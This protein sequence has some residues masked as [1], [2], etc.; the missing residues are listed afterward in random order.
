ML[1]IDLDHFKS[2]NDRFGHAVGD[3]ALQELFADI[4]KAHIGLAGT[5]GRWGGDEFV[6]VLYNASREIA[7]TARTHPGRWKRRQGNI[8]GRLVNATVISTGKEISSHGAFE[9]PSML[10][11]ADQ[12]A[13]RSAKAEGRNRLAIAMP[14]IVASDGRRQ[15]CR[16]DRAAQRCG[17]TER[18]FRWVGDSRRAPRHALR[19]L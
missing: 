13:L 10:L 8:G 3:R 1:L 7:A 2:I 6:A 4:A 19:R 18:R 11:K 9:L 15:Q 14:E 17:L 12:A 16:T 5:V